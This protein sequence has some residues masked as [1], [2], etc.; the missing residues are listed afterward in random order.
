MPEGQGACQGIGR[1]GVRRGLKP[2]QL[3][4]HMGHLGLVGSARAHN[5]L[6]HLQGGD[7]MNINALGCKCGNG[8]APGLTERQGRLRVH[9]HKD[10]FNDSAVGLKLGK[11]LSHFGVELGEPLW[12]ACLGFGT[13]DAACQVDGRACCPRGPSFNKPKAGSAQARVNT[14]QPHC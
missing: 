13:N 12:L 5:G 8:H 11:E 4:D 3:A 6:L 1:I 9:V 10:T 7:F 2:K 14:K